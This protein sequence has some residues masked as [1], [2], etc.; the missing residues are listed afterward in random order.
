MDRQLCVGRALSG[1][2]PGVGLG[3]ARLKVFDV[4]VWVGVGAH[5]SRRDRTDQNLKIYPVDKRA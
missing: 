2:L 3:D 4:Q 1:Q 5:L